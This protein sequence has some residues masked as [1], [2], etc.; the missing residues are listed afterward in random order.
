MPVQANQLHF[1]RFKSTFLDNL[2]DLF[3]NMVDLTEGL[4][5]STNSFLASI[6]MCKS[7]NKSTPLAIKSLI[8]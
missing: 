3:H 1:S 4:C 2:N 5:K 7:Q 8:A 6:L